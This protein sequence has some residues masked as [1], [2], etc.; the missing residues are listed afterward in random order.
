[1]SAAHEGSIGE[2]SRSYRHRPL[3]R[4]PEATTASR[5]Q[6][7][8]SALLCTRP[9]YFYVFKLNADLGVRLLRAGARRKAY[10][11]RCARRSAKSRMCSR[12]DQ[13]PTV[14]ISM[15]RTQA[16][17]SVKSVCAS[18]YY[19]RI[20]HEYKGSADSVVLK[21]LAKVKNKSR[22]LPQHLLSSI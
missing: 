10:S 9:S 14:G 5:R 12:K 21:H 13:F 1:M 18:P 3:E 6:M 4:A 22:P 15:K 2:T 8:P 19:A 16:S 17:V 7:T 20:V 11:T